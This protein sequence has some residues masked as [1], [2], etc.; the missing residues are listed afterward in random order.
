MALL[1]CLAFILSFSALAQQEKSP[2]PIDVKEGTELPAFAKALFGNQRANIYLS[3]EGKEIVMGIVTENGVITQ[4]KEGEVEKPTIKGYVSQETIASISAS[5]NPLAALREALDKKEIRYEVLGIGNKIKFSLI[6]FFVK[7]GS[8]FA[9]SIEEEPVAEA[10]STITSSVV[11]ETEPAVDESNESKNETETK[12]E[13]VPPSEEE[14]LP[15]VPRKIKHQ[16][17]MTSTGF[18][19]RILEIKKGETVVWE[20]VREGSIGVGMVIGVRNCF[21]VRSKKFDPGE[22]FEWTFTE[23][24]TC[25]IVDGIMST[26]DSKIVVKE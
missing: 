25:V 4:I 23:V 13:E 7:M 8:L 3:S 2:F 22:R 5:S 16:V 21:D 24:E 11:V 15:E 6:S 10:G 1:F 12:V 19:P 20:V 14:P 17:M 9:K 26:M 18:D